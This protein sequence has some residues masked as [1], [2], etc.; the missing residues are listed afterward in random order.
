MTDDV[1]GSATAEQP[2]AGSPSESNGADGGN[3]GSLAPGSQD[4]AVDHFAGLDAGSREW[5]E[6]NGI[7]SA[8]DAV[9]AA[10]ESQS[11]I[12][13][14]VQLPGDDAKPEDLQKFYGKLGRPENAEGYEFKLPEGIPEDLP[15]DA[16]FAG[17]FKPVAHELG[18]SGK[19]AAGL[20]DWFV[21]TQAEGFGKSREAMAGNAV[22]AT[23]AFEAKWGPQDG[24][25]FK[26]KVAVADRALEGLGIKQAFEA[27]GLLAPGGIVLDPAIGFALAQV[28]EAMFKED[29]LESGG[30]GYA[31]NPFAGSNLTEQMKAIKADRPRAL[32][33][34]AAAGKMPGDFGLS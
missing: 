18:L 10:R 25:T 11:L 29:S 9:K 2:N 30:T 4:S 33:M 19:Q 26:G 28:G 32:R 5:V 27:T 24:E 8:A 13:R 12:G 14:S 20:H 23:E 34:I 21:K 22:K 17:S 31:D 16:E 6:K 3:N 1:S 7:K 15:Y